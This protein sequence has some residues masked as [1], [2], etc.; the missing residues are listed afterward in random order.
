DASVAARLVSWAAADLRNHVERVID[1]WRAHI[2]TLANQRDRLRER[3]KPLADLER[4]TSEDTETRGRIV[5]ELRYVAG[6][7]TR[8]KSQD[9]LG[10]LE[11]LGLLPTYTLSDE[12]VTLEVSLWRPNDAH[13]P[14]DEQSRRFIPNGAEYTRP[15]SIAIREL[16]PGNYFYV[17]AH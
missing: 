6:R 9:T 14:G 12:T 1:R 7:I 11:A 10:A 5:A 13:D 4:P 17:D 8:A 2:Q 3:E 15:A 16:A